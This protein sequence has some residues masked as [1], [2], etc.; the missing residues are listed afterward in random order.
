MNRAV[1][2]DNQLT[3]PA[4]CLRRLALTGVIACGLIAAGMLSPAAA[5]S[6]FTMRSSSPFPALINLPSRWPDTNQ[7]A[8]DLSWNMASHSMSLQTDN[9]SLLLDGETHTLTARMQQS[10]GKRTRIG[11]E[12]PWI[13][14]SGGFMDSMIDGWH[15][16]FGLPEGIRPAVPKNDLRFV[17]L[18]DGVESYRLDQRASGI[19]D[20]RLS[21]SYDLT[22]NDFAAMALTG[23]IKLPTGD[24]A[25]LTGSDSTDVSMGLGISSPNAGDK[26]ISWWIDLGVIWP[27]DVAIPGLEESG[28]IFYYNAALTWH[29]FSSVDF[30]V[31]FNGYS[32][33]Y[34]SATRA[35]GK[36]GGQVGLGFDWRVSKRY[37]VR[38]GI[39][40]DIIVETAPDFGAEIAISVKY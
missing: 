14:H 36:S 24:L 8:F 12:L 5:Q 25:K 10:F 27:G 15:D 33:P 18:V 28:Q 26:N 9:E 23:G 30:L 17:Y 16:F 3:L 32:A 7:R 31:Q 6:G 1:C 34:K 4:A 21:L 20:I 37:S 40:E 13:S 2:P 29:A 39:F 22:Q 19:G 11:L 35:L 38:F